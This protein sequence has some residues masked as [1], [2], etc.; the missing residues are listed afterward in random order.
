MSN[1]P[2]THLLNS[3]RIKF[4]SIYFCAVLYTLYRK[5]LLVSKPQRSVQ[6]KRILRISMHLNIFK[7]VSI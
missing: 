4:W 5:K 7:T 6:N 1:S 3:I 2:F